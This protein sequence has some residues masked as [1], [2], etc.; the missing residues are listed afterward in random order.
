[1]ISQNRERTLG[2]YKDTCSTAFKSCNQKKDKEG[3]GMN[4]SG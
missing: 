3:A 4:A 2:F 1:M